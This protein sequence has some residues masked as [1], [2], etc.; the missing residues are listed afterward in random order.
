MRVADL[1]AGTGSATKFFEERGHVVDRYDLPDGDVTKLHFSRG[2]YDFIWAS[3]P[4]QDYAKLRM[5]QWFPEPFEIDLTVWEHCRRLILE[6]D[7][8]FYVIENSLGAKRIWGPPSHTN[9]AWT[10]WGNL[11][12]WPKGSWWKG[13]SRSGPR[14]K[15]TKSP[16]KRAVL[17]EKLARQFPILVERGLIVQE[18]LDKFFNPPPS[19]SCGHSEKG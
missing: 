15:Y 4:C 5:L 16:V 7:P 1:C 19:A 13:T 10:F 11:I 14:C 18:K 12:S 6:A 17:P 8:K 2:Q 3:P 9:G